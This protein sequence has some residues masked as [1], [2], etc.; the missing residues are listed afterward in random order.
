MTKSKSE[1]LPPWQTVHGLKLETIFWGEWCS[2][3]TAQRLK[4]APVN[5]VGNCQLRF[6]GTKG[7]SNWKGGTSWS[8]HKR[9]AWIIN[10]INF[11]I[12]WL[13]THNWIISASLSTCL[14]FIKIRFTDQSLPEIIN[15]PIITRI[16]KLVELAEPVDE[17]RYWCVQSYALEHTLH[18]L[19]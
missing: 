1:F 5:I 2:S 15:W 18:R 11:H 12:C 19:Q 13:L 4:S 14:F 16:R 17:A 7:M 8:N 10:K 9:E 6:F 3:P